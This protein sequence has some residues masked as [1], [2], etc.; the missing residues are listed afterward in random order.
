MKILLATDGSENSEGAAKFLTR[1]NFSSDDEILVLHAVSWTPLMSEM[2]AFYV[3][4]KGLM[5]DIAPK[6]LKATADILITVKAKV[7]TSSVEDFPDKAIVNT[8]GDSGAALIVM[9]AKGRR[10]LE[11]LIVGSVTKLVAIKSPVPVLAVNPP[12]W[13]ETGK[14]KILFAS[15]GS[16]YSDAMGKTLASIPFP[17]DTEVTVL[18]VVFSALSDIPERFAF[19]INKKIKEM[20]ASTREAEFKESDKI[21]KKAREY[22]GGRF[23]K[24]EVLSKSGD[25]SIEILKTAKDI[26]ADIIAVGSSGMRGIR[27]ML[28]SVSRYV[29]NHSRCSVLIGKT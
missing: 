24:I 5:E 11:S 3:D 12:Q 14:L 17:A 25:P 13:K 10:G 29:L 27:G 8:A 1:F 19:G 15:D 16:V 23:S 22:L 6:I 7:S 21:T 20:V 9:G 2:E 18:N 28:G 26:N 4:V